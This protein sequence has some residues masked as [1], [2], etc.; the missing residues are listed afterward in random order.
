M[1]ETIRRGVIAPSL[2][3]SYSHTDDDIDRTIEAIDGAL[4]VYRRALEDGPEGYLVGRAVRPTLRNFG[5]KWREPT[6]DVQVLN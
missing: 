3:V 6:T 2:V 5:D 4:H 1:Q